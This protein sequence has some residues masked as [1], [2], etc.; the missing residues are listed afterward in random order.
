MPI[1]LREVTDSDVDVF[2]AL[3][4]DPIAAH[5][6]AF[7]AKDLDASAYVARW[8]TH[9][10]TPSTTQRAIVF[11]GVVVGFVASFRR[12]T[13]LEVTYWVARSHWGRGIAR[14]ALTQLLQIVTHR[15]VHASAVKDN[16]GS[17]RVLARC[18]FDVCGEE[19][20][21]AEARGELVDEVFMILR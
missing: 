10:T 16:V 2:V 20:T 21:F 12:E 17:L 1:E 19:R 11:E 13:N 14:E 9:A 8:R 3:Q 7:G 5:L 18:G 6:A 15:P 4:C